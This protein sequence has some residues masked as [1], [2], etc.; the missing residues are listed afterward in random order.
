M[1]VCVC[2]R[3]CHHAC[4][5]SR[6]FACLCRVAACLHACMPACLRLTRYVLV[7]T[8]R[9]TVPFTRPDF[10][11]CSIFN[12]PPPSN[13]PH[14]HL[15]FPTNV[16]S[17]TLSNP[18]QPSLF[19]FLALSPFFSL[20]SSLSLFESCRPPLFSTTLSFPPFVFFSFPSQ[21]P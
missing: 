11:F 19:P 14:Q 3:A 16:A 2:A 7:F 17:P 18:L 15:L 10:P 4:C 5:V 13:S 6:L 9:L 1:C 8:N 12:H 21:L 20:S